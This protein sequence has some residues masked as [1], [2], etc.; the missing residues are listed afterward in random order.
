MRTSK[1]AG[2]LY[3]LFPERDVEDLRVGPLGKGLPRGRFVQFRFS[4]SGT[5]EETVPAGLC[6][7]GHDHLLKRARKAIE[8]HTTP[9]VET[10]P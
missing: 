10:V 4:R 6:G 8:E 2:K 3:V 1:V 9:S 5:L 7:P